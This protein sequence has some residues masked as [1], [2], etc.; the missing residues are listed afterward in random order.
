MRGLAI[1]FIIII[2]LSSGTVGFWVGRA[3]RAL[4]RWLDKYDR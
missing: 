2:I 1:L 4:K 3:T